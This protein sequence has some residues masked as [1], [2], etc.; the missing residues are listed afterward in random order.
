MRRNSIFWGLAAILVGVV[1]LLNTLGL[2]PG[3]AWTYI[4]GFFLILLGLWFLISPRL[5]QHSQAEAET[6]TLPL[7]G[8]HRAEIRIHHGAGELNL[9]ALANSSDLLS[10]RFVGGVR[11]KEHYHSDRV[12]VKLEPF[13]EVFIPPAIPPSPGLSW[14]LA[15][16]RAV[17]LQLELH[18]G[19]S[20]SNLDLRDLRVT[21]LRL[22]TGASATVLDLPVNAGH[23]RF[24]AETG[25]AS[26]EVHVPQGVAARI[27]VE[28]GL[29]GVNVDL[30]RFPSNGR[31]YQSGDYE[32]AAN[33]VEMRIQTGVG[34]VDIR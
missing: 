27:E 31:F 5:F 24:E 20:S 11:H 22:E 23:T 29:A 18:T 6:L 21:Y 9:S 3:N 7:D 34:S 14:D 28:S 17:E 33:R 8:A 2:L 25:A 15:L 13:S 26:L 30:A 32:T 12:T 19:A 4:W 16:S 1:L 10:G